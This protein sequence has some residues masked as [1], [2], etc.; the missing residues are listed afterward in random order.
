VK[1]KVLFDMDGVIVKTEH[2]KAAAHEAAVA[3]FGGCVPENLYASVIGQTHNDVRAAFIRAAGI[4]IDP[5]GYTR[6]YRRVYSVS[7]DTEVELVPGIGELLAALDVKGFQL[8]LVTSSTRPPAEKLLGKFHLDH[9]FRVKI[10]A[11]DVQHGKPDPEPYIK[12]LEKLSARPA[13]TIV[14]EDSLSGII[15]ANAA[16]LTVITLRHLYNQQ[17]DFSLAFAVLDSLADTRKVM[18]LIEQAI[19]FQRERSNEWKQQN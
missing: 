4:P 2:L 5:D 14:L 12:A 19:A 9:F 17:Q 15:A 10:C 16:R 18:E 3:K 6:E 8:A 11:E 13:D 1:K 7:L